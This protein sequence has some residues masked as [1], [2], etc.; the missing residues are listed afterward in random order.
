MIAAASPESVFSTTKVRKATSRGACRKGSLA[1]TRARA[2]RKASTSWGAYQLAFL[3]GVSEA[4]RAGLVV[5]HRARLRL[6]RQ[7]TSELLRLGRTSGRH[8]MS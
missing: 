3:E 7:A 5:K 4:S 2:A 1:T 6:S 8:S